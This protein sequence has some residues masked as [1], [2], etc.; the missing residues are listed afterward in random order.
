MKKT[1]KALI[2]IALSFATILTFVSC[3]LGTNQV[4][5]DFIDDP[6]MRGF[7]AFSDT[8]AIAEIL[9]AELPDEEISLVPVY[10]C[11]GLYTDGEPLFL[12]AIDKENASALGLEEMA[13]DTM[14]FTEASADSVELE[15]RVTKEEEG[16][17]LE[18]DIAYMTLNA[19][20]GVKGKLLKTVQKEFMTPSVLEGLFCFVNMETYTKIASAHLDKEITDIEPEIDSSSLLDFKGVVIETNKA[21]RVEKILEAHNYY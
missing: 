7:L 14:Y 9:E 19:E 16:G 5:I 18:Y 20:S 11:G 12:Y 8:Q 21:G 10:S 3:G 13:D 6:D 17:Y 15:I 2:A 4:V 1:L